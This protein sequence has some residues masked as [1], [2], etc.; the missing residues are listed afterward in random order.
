[1]SVKCEA[2]MNIELLSLDLEGSPGR[3]FLPFIIVNKD[4]GITKSCFSYPGSRCLHLD[5]FQNM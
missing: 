5:I 2:T 4:A 1:M 3:S